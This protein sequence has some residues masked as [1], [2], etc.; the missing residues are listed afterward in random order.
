MKKKRKSQKAIMADSETIRTR[1]AKI[2]YECCELFHGR[3]KYCPQCLPDV[4]K[5]KKDLGL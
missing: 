4:K 3:S 5:L 2:C 1:P